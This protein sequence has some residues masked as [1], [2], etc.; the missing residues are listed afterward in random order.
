MQCVTD[1]WCSPIGLTTIMVPIA[2]LMPIWNCTQLTAIAKNGP[3]GI[4]NISIL[5]MSMQMGM[6]EPLQSKYMLDTKII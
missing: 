2:F 6:S 1:S 4:L 5:H 3:N